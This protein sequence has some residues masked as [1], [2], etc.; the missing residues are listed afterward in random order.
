MK[1]LNGIGTGLSLTV[2]C[3]L[4]APK[5][6]AD[7]QDSKTVVILSAPIAVPGVGAQTLPAG[8]YLFK[9]LNSS[10]DRDIIQI[11]NQDETHV[12]A[13]VIGV[14]NSRLKASDKMVTMYD[15]RPAGE[16]Q[17]LKAW[18]YPGR[19]WGDQIVY[20]KP[21]AIQLAKEANEAVLSTS[22][23]LITSP[24]AMLSTAQIEAVSPSGDTVD[25]TQ[26]VDAPLVVAPALAADAGPAV[27]VEPSAAAAPA[28]APATVAATE[29]APS[30]EPVATATPAVAAEPADQ[31]ATVTAEPTV[32]AEPVAAATPA[33]VAE[34]TTPAEPVVAAVPADQPAPVAAEPAIA[35]APV[36][37][38]EPPATATPTA[39]VEPAAT[40]EPAPAAEPAPAPEPAV[41]PTPVATADALPKTSSLLPLIGLA[42][43]L[44]L[45]AGFSLSSRSKRRS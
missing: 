36:A 7:E 31:A 2:L 11:S 3:L 39:A 26:V 34:S 1:L 29:P 44:M 14:P 8:T 19:A 23:S 38:T 35:P 6:K 13:T 9:D 30:A 41:A 4:M 20:E 5:A 40:P 28:V 32:A 16:P 12:F 24:V 21:M 42:G 10:S 15:E 25:T 22:A 27:A 18:F 33:P 37:A 45:G 43:L 17:A